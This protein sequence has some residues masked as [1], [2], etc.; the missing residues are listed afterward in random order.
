MEKQR[1]HIN[2]PH[3]PDW[4]RD[5]PIGWHG[6][7]SY[8]GTTD[9]A[10]LSPLKGENPTR[11]SSPFRGV[12]WAG[13]LCILS[14]L[15]LL[16]SCCGSQESD[17][18]HH[19]ADSLIAAGRSDSA[20]TLLQTCDSKAPHWPRRRQ[21]HHELLRARAMNKAY[22]TFTTD[23]VMKQTAEWYD[24]HGTPNE[25][26]EAHYLLGCTYRDMGE[27]PAALLSY[28]DAVD[29]ADDMAENDCNYELLSRIHGQMGNLFLSQ[30]LYR[31]A[32]N[33]FNLSSS[34]AWKGND[35]LMAV[36]AYGQCAD[37]Y[38][39]MGCTDSALIAFYTTYKNLEK[40]GY[41]NYANTFLS[42]P[43]YI[44]LSKGELDDAKRYL[45]IYEHHSAVSEKGNAVIDEYRKL[46]YYKGIYFRDRGE[47]DSATN[48]LRAFAVQSKS[49][50][51]KMLAYSALYSVYRLGSS[52]DSLCK[53]IDLYKES[54]DSVARTIEASK[55]QDLQSLYNY[56]RQQV[57]AA[58]EAER[59]DK[60]LFWLCI[61]TSVLVIVILSVRLIMK[62]KQ[63]TNR[64]L[65][66]RMTEKNIDIFIRFQLLKT[67]RENM[68]RQKNYLSKR[69]GEL[70]SELESVKADSENLRKGNAIALSEKTAIEAKLK[71][72]TER[73][74]TIT[75]EYEEA[76]ILLSQYSEK[77]I[78][79]WNVEE[80]IFSTPIVTELHKQAIGSKTVSETFW[81]E[82][83]NA[84]RPLMP[85][86]MSVVDSF[87]LRPSSKGYKLC[88]L[89]RLEF[90]LPE[91]CVL[92]DMS[93]QS[94]NIMRRRM[95]KKLFG[96]SEEAK[97]FDENIRSI[98]R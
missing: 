77:D 18:L 46:L 43:I 74:D 65:L 36:L 82:L 79:K 48:C 42:I 8:V 91:I 68:T 29:Y 61:A 47:T 84:I 39:G 33:S 13:A 51:D 55:L 3:L 9:P 94:L 32:L 41:T 37:C 67:E 88:I 50:G 62:H 27:A 30:S 28:Q 35:T 21:M 86:F 5:C 24:R 58:K 56:T 63:E 92:L 22:I 49:E 45:D 76:K 4:Y 80:A 60:L 70:C 57:I 78:K 44:L 87:N 40:Y 64:K 59:A 11:N 20:I 53:Y 26:M 10:P 54:L 12:R 97:L 73:L 2:A 25:Q 17:A 34:Y 66:N 90:S 85:N 7:C 93:S 95:N 72:I 81:K 19:V 6:A 16:S 83:D 1:I 69:Y 98:K 89:T 75:V 15:I 38:Y 23:S 14:A 31:N 52:T 71:E 96:G